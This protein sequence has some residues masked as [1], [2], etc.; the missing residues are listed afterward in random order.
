MSDCDNLVEFHGS[1]IFSADGDSK[2]VEKSGEEY[3]HSFSTDNGRVSW[4]KKGED[5]YLVSLTK[6]DHEV[7][8]RL[9][10]YDQLKDW[11]Y[12]PTSEYFDNTISNIPVES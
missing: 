11:F 8:S 6:P 3:D 7:E 9:L 1:F 4:E 12:A 2:G 5:S 10:T